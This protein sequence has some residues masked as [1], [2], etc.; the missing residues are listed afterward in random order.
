MGFTRT[1][2]DST[3]SFIRSTRGKSWSS[4]LRSAT[5]EKFIGNNGA[6]R[7]KPVVPGLPRLAPR[8]RTA[9]SGV[10]SRKFLKEKFLGI[11]CD[12]ILFNNF[13]TLVG[14]IR[15]RFTRGFA[16][17]RTSRR[18]K[19]SFAFIHGQSP[20][21]SAKADK[22]SVI[23]PLLPRLSDIN[24]KSPNI[25]GTGPVLQQGGLGVG[26]QFTTQGRNSPGYVNNAFDHSPVIFLGEFGQGGAIYP[27]AD[28]LNVHG[29]IV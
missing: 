8:N 10:K 4:F 14:V 21:S 29:N 23:H 16:I 5:G 13:V 26:V 24:I 25:F 27:G 9:I 19:N 2:W 18:S 11:R 12:E 28:Q 20:W 7:A 22:G 17:R 3:G 6:P 1:A 15:R